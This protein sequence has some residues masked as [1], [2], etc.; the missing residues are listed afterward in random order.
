MYCAQMEQKS[1][2]FIL[3]NGIPYVI[4]KNKS[5]FH[6][7]QYKSSFLSIESYFTNLC[8]YDFKPS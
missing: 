5:N 1:L 6:E 3:C 7:N 2:Y 4:L 8:I